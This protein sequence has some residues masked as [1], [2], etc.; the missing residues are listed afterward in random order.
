[1][2]AGLKTV[3]EYPDNW[4]QVY[5]DGSAFKGTINAGY[6]VRIEYTD[7]TTEEWLQAQGIREE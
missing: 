1:M 4:T 7:K 6:G 2:V 5:T 3:Q